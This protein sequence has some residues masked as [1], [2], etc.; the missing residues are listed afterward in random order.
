[1]FENFNADRNWRRECFERFSAKTIAHLNFCE[2]IYRFTDVFWIKFLESLSTRWPWFRV[3]FYSVVASFF[4]WLLGSRYP[5]FQRIFFSYR[6]WSF[7]AMPRQ[8]GAKRREKKNHR[9][10]ESHFHA[11]NHRSYESHFHAILGSYISSNRFGAD[12]HVCF[13]WRWQLRFDRTW[14]ST[15]HE[16]RIAQ[17]LT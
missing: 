13:H 2:N 7:A 8:R 6:Y 12:V 5:G 3:P 4:S 10:Y 14:L 9:S 15:I 11:K 17:K 1:M 16:K